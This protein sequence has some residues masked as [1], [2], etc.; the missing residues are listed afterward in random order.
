M[1][2]LKLKNETN[3]VQKEIPEIDLKTVTARDLIQEASNGEHQFLEAKDG[4]RWYIISSK[5][6]ESIPDDKM[7]TSLEDLGFS[8][9][10]TVG[11]IAKGLA[12]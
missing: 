9:G 7:D 2:T 8:D 10:D 5:T 1:A 4:M 12:A 3:G 11:F 6:K